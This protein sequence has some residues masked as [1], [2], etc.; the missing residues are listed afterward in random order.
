MNCPLCK[1]PMTKTEHD[2]DNTYYKTDVYTCPN[3]DYLF[4]HNNYDSTEVEQFEVTDSDYIGLDG[5][6]IVLEVSNYL[7]YKLVNNRS[8]KPDRHSKVRH[9]GIVVFAYSDHIPVGSN[10][11]QVFKLLQ[12]A[13]LW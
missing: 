9:N 6:Q 7:D 5:Y 4:V 3:Q 12:Q 13:R 2:L 11:H 8:K 1:S 10:P